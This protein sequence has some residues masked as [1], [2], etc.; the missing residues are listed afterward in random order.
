[1]TPS[2]IEEI[3]AVLWTILWVI[4]WANN[5][6]PFALWLVGIKAGL[7]HLCSIGFAIQE[8]REKGK[9]VKR[10]KIIK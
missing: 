6:H 7:D 5:A 1:M 3:I 4:L 10:T 2:K 8:I 9:S